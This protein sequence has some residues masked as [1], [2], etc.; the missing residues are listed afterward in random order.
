MANTKSDESSST[1]L[2]IFVGNDVIVVK[3]GT[4]VPS[5]EGSQYYLRVNAK[6]YLEFLL[7]SHC[8]SLETFYGKQNGT[9]E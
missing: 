9:I 8:S 6:N 7:L 5:F 3:S 1:K 2:L 4:H